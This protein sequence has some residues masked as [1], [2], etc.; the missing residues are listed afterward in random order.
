MDTDGHDSIGWG[1]TSTRDFTVQSAY[2]YQSVGGQTFEGDW[3]A[4][5][6]WKGPHRIQTFMWMAA[7]E[8]LL[9]NY[10]RSKWGVGISPMCPD[11]DRDN[12]TTLHVLRDCPKATQIW[13]RLVPSNQITNFFSLNCR[14]WIFR[15]ISNQPQGIQSKKWTTTF[16][17]ACWH[18]WTWRNKTI[19]EDDFQYPTN[20]TY[21]ILKMVDEIDNCNHNPMN[22]YHGNTIF[23]GWKKPQEGWVKL[24]C[25]R[26]Y[27]DSLELAGCGG[28]LRD[29]DGRWLTGYS[30]KIGTCDALGAEMWG[31]YLGMQIA[32]RQGFNNLQVESDSKML[33][34]MITGKA[35]ING[36][37]PTLVRR[38]QELLKLNWQ[39]QINHTWR[40][41]NRCADWL[42]NFSF[43]LNSFQIHVMK[44]R[45]SGIS[46]LLF[47]D[48]SGACMPRNIRV[49]V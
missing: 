30:R 35:R 1:G 20:P 41:G 18:I 6:S 13:I 34:D 46:S 38:I 9:T 23:I 4:L 17:V 33:V 3:K 40:E 49:I 44:T 47:D 42:A 39:V 26:A 48:I 14:D 36:K 10:W 29:S 45:P 19:F 7:H 22:L 43:S 5:W 8:R 2:V 12:E 11:C 37:P 31:M 21:I 25:D 27:K 24:N 15:N 28:L 16:L 32:W